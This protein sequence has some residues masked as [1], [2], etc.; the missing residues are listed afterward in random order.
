MAQSSSQHVPVLLEEVLQWLR[1]SAGKTYVDGT[2]GGGSHARKL[3]DAV[4][5]GGLIVAVDRDQAVVERARVELVDLPIQ[6]EHANYAN[7]PSLLAENETGLVDGILLDLGLSS[8]QLADHDRGFSFRCDGPL[9][10]RFDRS[11]GEPAWKLIDR[12]SAEHLAD[13]IYQF[14][15]ER[16]SRRIARAIVQRRQSQPIRTAGELAELVSKCVP[17]GK[18]NRIDPATRTFQALRI[19]VNEELD[20]L[21]VALRHFPDCLR[22]GGRLAI[23]SFHSLEDRP[24]KHAFRND[25]RLEVLTRR[26]IR[27]SAEE[28]ARNPRARSAKLRVAERLPQGPTEKCS[29][30]LL[31]GS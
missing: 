1:P 26:P 31:P 30:P 14:G 4:G 18:A 17:R 24:V 12:L 25:P 7:L 21:D 22:P 11:T 10:L 8:D 28:V 3:A 16:M 2:L 23:I 20:W 5:R 6:V 15:E 13:L 19:A 29:N 9:D 27:A